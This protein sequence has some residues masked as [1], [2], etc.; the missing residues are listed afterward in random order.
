MQSTKWEL[1]EYQRP[2]SFIDL[3]PN[4]SDFSIFFKLLFLNN[5]WF[6][7]ILSTQVSDTAP[8]VLWFSHITTVCGCHRELSAHFYSAV[9]L[10]YYAPDTW[11]DTTPSHIILTLGRPVLALPLSLSAKRGA[12]STIFN[13]FGMSQHGIEPVTSSSPE[14]DT[15][16]WATK[17]FVCNVSSDITFFVCTISSDRTH[18]ILMCINIIMS[19]HYTF[20]YVQ[21][22]GLIRI[23]HKSRSPS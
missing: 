7:H 9:S 14:A 3:G 22:T 11:H 18:F 2:R 19:T 21:L 10:K 23:R 12:T 1:Y 4:H 20:S 16:T 13:D 5:R 17:L 8:M 15:T 6:W